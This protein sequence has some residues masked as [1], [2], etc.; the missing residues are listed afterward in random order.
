VLSDLGNPLEYPRYAAGLP[1]QRGRMLI[2]ERLAIGH[3]QL[4]IISS[5]RGSA[6]V[7]KMR[8]EGY[9]SRKS[10]RAARMVWSLIELQCAA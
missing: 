3:V 8:Q 2:E 9:P 7:E 4:S 5:G 6:I 1:R 10:R